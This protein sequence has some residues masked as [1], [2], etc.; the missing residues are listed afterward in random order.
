[1]VIPRIFHEIWVGAEP[2]PKRLGP[3][4]HSWLELN[5]GWE[6]RF[7][8]EDNLP[9]D[10]RRPEALERLRLEL[11]WRF[12][13]VYVDC[14]FECLRPIEPLIEDYD[15]FCAYQEPDRVNNAL[16]G[17][18]PGHPILDCALDEL[19]P[20]DVCG[21][22]ESA[23]GSVFLDR[24]LREHPEA[25]IF[26]PGVFYPTRPEQREAAYAVHHERLSWKDADGLRVELAK[27]ERLVSERQAEAFEWKQRYMRAQ[28]ELER[29][30]SGSQA[31]L[32]RPP[33]SSRPS[34]LSPGEQLIP[35]IFHQIWLGPDPVPE[36]YAAYRQTWIDRHPGWLLRVWTDDNLLEGAH[37][38]EVYETLRTPAERADMLRLELL[39]R[40]G[41][42]YVDC[43]FECVRPIEPLLGGVEFFAGYR[44]PGHA[45]NAIMGSVAG[46]P[47]VGRALDEIR[48]RTTYG[49]VDKE[50]TGPLFLNR[51]L[52]EFPG[53][54]LFDP[55]VFYPRSP[56]AVQEAYAVHHRARTWKDP[57]GLRR[58]VRK[59]E[60]RLLSAIEDA[61]QRQL[62]AGQA[63]AELAR[64]KGT[65]PFAQLGASRTSR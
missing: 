7:W 56:A 15:F 1:V 14:D 25:R 41:G 12:G 62:Q 17:A 20:T 38:G 34:P 31:E 52:A 11:L 18:V 5:P 9:R 42:V 53:V 10:L 24:L 26:E 37:R 63:E 57:D 40:F 49:P 27:L 64:V 54:T 36:E 4:R 32:K 6:L 46:H 16:I 65:L 21:Y 30:Q 55:G 59:A 50:G 43:D 8:T 47:L 13:G 45:N 51:I 35:R 58:S 33:N 48:P 22:D 60:R 61:R 28:A 44:K 19:K 3:Y 39:W 2:F 23:A 29:L